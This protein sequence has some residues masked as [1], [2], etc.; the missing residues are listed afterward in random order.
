MRIWH[1]LLALLCLLVSSPAFAQCVDINSASSTELQRI[2]HI[3]PVR[4]AELIAKRPFSSV[5]DLVRI[6]G[7]AAARLQDIKN[8]GLA[9]VRSSTP[10]PTPTPS[11]SPAPSPTP[12]PTP[13]PEPVVATDR[14]T[15]QFAAADV[16]PGALRISLTTGEV[17][18]IPASE[19]VYV[20]DEWPHWLD[21]DGDCQDA[22]QE[23]L[24]AES[25]TPPVLDL[26]GCRVVSGWWVDPLTGQEFT[27]PS[28]LDVDHHVPLA[29]AFRSGGWGWNRA[30]RTRFANYLLDPWHLTAMSASANRSKGDR[31]PD[32]WRPPL[33]SA[34]CNY[35]REWT[36]VK[37]R[38]L[39][40]ITAPEQAAVNE[41]LATCSP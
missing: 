38:W 22:R 20:R 13:V 12:P 24:I 6:D 4:A 18:I 5:D 32:E 2:I 33:Q 36:M 27:N 40:T 29:N 14:V 11:P 1:L 23:V 16:L 37:Q 34:W 19:L 25:R 7:I 15:I 31:G 10:A 26:A 9:C 8:Q 21:E 41:M 39:L 35:A 3:G 17:F 28:E 30:T